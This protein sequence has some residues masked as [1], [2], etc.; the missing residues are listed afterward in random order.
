[1][2]YTEK[3]SEMLLVLEILHKNI[4]IFEVFK[5]GAFSNFC[6]IRPKPV[7]NIFK[8]IKGLNNVFFFCKM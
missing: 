6:L 3:I 5:A 8:D 4:N 7:Q 2:S 1:M